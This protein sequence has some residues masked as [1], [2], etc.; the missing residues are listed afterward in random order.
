MIIV[1]RLA[2]GS[3]GE[4]AMR[5]VE[6]REYKAAAR[7]WHRERCELHAAYVSALNRRLGSGATERSAEE[8]NLR[9]EL[10]NLDRS[11]AG[12]VRVLLGVLD[13]AGVGD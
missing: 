8:Q 2:I 13:S 12:H 5:N 9:V 10:R 1:Y 3:L 6:M 7:Q 11:G 4:M